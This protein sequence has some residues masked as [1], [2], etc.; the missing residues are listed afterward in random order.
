MR[1]AF[2][3]LAVLSAGA[4]LDAPAARACE[5]VAVLSQPAA[6]PVIGGTYAAHGYGYQA[7]SVPISQLPTLPPTTGYSN[8]A[9]GYYAP[10]P[11]V[12]VHPLPRPQPRVRVYRP[13]VY[14]PYTS[15]PYRRVIVY[16]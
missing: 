7:P 9:T 10:G 5:G 14:R 12:G 3:A 16:R 2:T 6:A 11:A 4:A 8:P 13:Y 1:A 15:R